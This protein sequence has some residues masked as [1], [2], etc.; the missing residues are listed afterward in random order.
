ML[1][2]CYISHILVVLI[3]EIQKPSLEQETKHLFLSKLLSDHFEPWI[4]CEHQQVF[5]PNINIGKKINHWCTK[6]YLQ[7]EI[8]HVNISLTEFGWAGLS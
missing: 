4:A 1:K 7:G 3:P 5:L 2:F 6:G 8:T